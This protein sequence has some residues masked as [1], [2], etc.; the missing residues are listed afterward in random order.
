MAKIKRSTLG[1]IAEMVLYLKAGAR[2]FEVYGVDKVGRKVVLIR[3][4]ELEP[5][6]ADA[7]SAAQALANFRKKTAQL[8]IQSGRVEEFNPE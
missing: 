1:V 4:K 5:C 6:V 7:A 2:G 3:R 8:D